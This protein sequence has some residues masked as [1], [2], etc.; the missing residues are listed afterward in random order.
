MSIEAKRIILAIG[1]LIVWV[2]LISAGGIMTDFVIPA[3]AGW[4]VGGMIYSFVRK[5]FPNDS[6]N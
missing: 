5:V 2:G 4:L 6:E 1:C 3:L